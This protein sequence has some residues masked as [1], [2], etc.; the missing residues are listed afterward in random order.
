[1]NDTADLSNP[2]LNSGS[3][4]LWNIHDFTSLQDKWVNANVTT[5][6][7]TNEV[8]FTIDNSTMPELFSDEAGSLQLKVGFITN[9]GQQ[10]VQG[11]YKVLKSLKLS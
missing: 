2:D 4:D 8:V 5:N 11:S 9:Y 10:F 1:M 7:T 3:P 6:F